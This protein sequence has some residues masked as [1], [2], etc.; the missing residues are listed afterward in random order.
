MRL[1]ENKN[2]YREEIARIHKSFRH[3]DLNFLVKIVGALSE[4]ER[5]R[6]LIGVTI[7]K[8]SDGSQQGGITECCWG[9]TD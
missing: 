4:G 9:L 7:L 1:E 8:V 3:N 6:D 5:V 2:V